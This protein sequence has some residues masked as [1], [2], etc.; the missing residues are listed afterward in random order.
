MK[1]LTVCQPY[2]DLL[3]TPEKPIEN[4]PSWYSYRGS[5]L[6]HAGKSKA[7]LRPGDRASSFVYGAIIGVVTV[8]DSV[9][10]CELERKYPDLKDHPHASGPYCLIVKDPA[11]FVKPV[12]YRGM[13]GL[14]NVPD[15]IV[16]EAANYMKEHA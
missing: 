14:F 10:L 1:C 13:L 9:A 11:R 16:P 8:I 2:A 4:R 6:I 12:P 15:A 7:W 5:L 3:L